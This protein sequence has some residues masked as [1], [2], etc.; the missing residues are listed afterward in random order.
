[1]RRTPKLKKAKPQVVPS[2]QVS[3]S[4]VAQSLLACPF[5]L[6]ILLSIT[7]TAASISVL[8]SRMRPA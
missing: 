5:W 1:M 3:P 4:T 6:L 2:R 7:T 8:K